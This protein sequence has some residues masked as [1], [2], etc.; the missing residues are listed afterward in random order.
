MKVSVRSS[1][2]I[3]ECQ[4][5]TPDS[6]LRERERGVEWHSR[7]DSGGCITGGGAVGGSGAAG[8]MTN[9]ALP[10]S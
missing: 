4:D 2:A 10:R 1:T 7:L 9:V 5:E 8:V 3:V 6:I